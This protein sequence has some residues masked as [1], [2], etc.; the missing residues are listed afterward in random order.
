MA[1]KA[2]LG[3][4]RCLRRG[5]SKGAEEGKEQESVQQ[6]RGQSVL[7]GADEAGGLQRANSGSCEAGWDFIISNPDL[8][9]TLESRA[10]FI[11][12][13][14]DRQLDRLFF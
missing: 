7:I 13:G 10:I 9:F 2:S 4:W 3:R 6:C 5:I 12:T 8:G 1:G 11:P 14:P